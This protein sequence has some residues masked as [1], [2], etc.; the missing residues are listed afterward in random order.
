MSDADTAAGA[1][2]PPER[3]GPAW[4]TA[5]E[6]LLL[7]AIWGASFLFMR[8]AA[9]H[10]G[11]FALVEMRLG[12]G[13]L[14]LLPQLWRTWGRISAHQWLKLAGIAA[15][16]SAIPFVLFAWA[17]EG[18][19]AGVGAIANATTVMFTAL[20][21]LVFYGELIS[22]RRA[23]GLVAG[24]VGVIVLASGKMGGVSV[25]PAALAGT[26]AALLYGIGANLVRRQLVGLPAG[27]VAAATLLC[28]AILT[29]P[30]A[31]ATWPQAPIPAGSW[32]SAVL[33]GVL[34]TGF[35]FV[36]YYR[37]IHRIGAP[38][39]ATVTYL[40]PLFGVLWAWLVL[41]EPV[42]A[43]MAVAGALILG[44]VALNQQLGKAASAGEGSFRRTLRA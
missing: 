8:V 15:V 4:L 20:V 2:A 22:G 26:G 31:A 36:L 19:P 32:L 43:N 40:I 23:A 37:L 18:A 25:W 28:S 35:A 27:A 5:L 30:F 12:L 17:A 39:A 29:A 44:G 16:N 24:F 34:C 1:Q 13:A 42:T 33:L 14:V 7:G 21:A 41:G 9:G 38:R 6:L 3:P 11:A 10:F